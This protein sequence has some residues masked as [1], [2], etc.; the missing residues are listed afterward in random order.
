MDWQ[1]QVTQ[2]ENGIIT[3]TIEQAHAVVDSEQWLRLFER[4]VDSRVRG[5]ILDCSQ[6]TTPS[7]PLMSA[8][9]WCRQLAHRHGIEACV[10]GCQ[11]RLTRALE[12]TELTRVLLIAENAGA[13]IEL[14]LRPQ[15]GASGS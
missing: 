8:L 15:E 9:T 10:V 14:L 6:V 1:P 3:I 2:D 5:L 4:L 13:A 7:S 11:S 12:I